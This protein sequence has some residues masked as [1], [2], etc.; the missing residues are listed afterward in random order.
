M[1]AAME[2]ATSLLPAD[3]ADLEPLVAEWSLDCEEARFR[4]LH[5]VSM[6]ELRSFYDA[7]LPRLPAI[8]SFLR[9]CRLGAMSEPQK[10]LFH[11]AMTFVETSHPIDLGWA[12]TDFPGAYRWQAF[13]FRSVSCASR[14]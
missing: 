9:E 5:S 13:E 2:T 6:T 7:M 4:K 12:D 11:M 14:A 1:S 3:F 10:S 8:L